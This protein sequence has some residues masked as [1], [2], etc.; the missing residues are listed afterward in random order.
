ML[1]H[2]LL[3]LRRRE[4]IP[5]L[6]GTTSLGAHAVGEAA[7]LA[8]W[9]LG[10]GAVLTIACNLGERPAKTGDTGALLWES[11]AGAAATLGAGNL[12]PRCCVVLLDT[13]H[14]PSTLD[15]PMMKGPG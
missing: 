4:I 7:V 6:P 3:A 9:R 1:H 14:P 15:G 11:L 2:R 13:P 10:D 12:L 5:R 8:R